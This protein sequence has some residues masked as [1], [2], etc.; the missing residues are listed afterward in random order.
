VPDPD[1]DPVPESPADPAPDSPGELPLD[2]AAEAPPDI[3]PEPASEPG[4][5]LVPEDLPDEAVDAGVEPTDEPE[6][7]IPDTA[8]EPGPEDATD[9]GF[10]PDEVSIPAC[11]NDCPDEGA[12]G[13]SGSEVVTCLAG[14]DGCRHWAQEQSCDDQDP[15]TEDTCIPGTGCGHTPGTG[16]CDDG[17]PCTAGDTCVSGLCVPGTSV[18]QCQ[19][20]TECDGFEDGDAC[21]G[22]LICDIPGISG[23]PNTCVV[24]PAT[25]VSCDGSTDTACEKSRCDP[26]TGACGPV[27]EPDGT[28]CDDK[29]ACTFDDACTGGLCAGTVLACADKVLCTLDACEEGE[30]THGY[31]DPVG[32]EAIPFQLA[33]ANPHSPTYQSVL[34][35]ISETVGT[36]RVIAFH[37]C[38]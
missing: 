18:C 38:G 25:V 36:I 34:D 23:Q 10:A 22:T 13:C 24:D 30:C 8:A 9:P 4:P 29:D 27:A 1:P 31:A 14:A 19:S 28:A 6:P 5:E 16:P 21:N 17:N 11:T 3:P 2:A 26:G 7:D 32:R 20:D 37:S 33:D 15:C 12:L 35:P